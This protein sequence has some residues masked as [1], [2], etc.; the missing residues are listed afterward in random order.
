MN[1]KIFTSSELEPDWSRCRELEKI[2]DV[3][4][5]RA[6]GRSNFFGSDSMKSECHYYKESELWKIEMNE[7]SVTKAANVWV[8]SS[9]STRE[10]SRKEEED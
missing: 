1:Y 10:S 9:L 3:T 6:S 2:L 8:S 7:I 4:T 5:R